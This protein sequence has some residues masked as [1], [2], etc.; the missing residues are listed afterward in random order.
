MAVCKIL[1]KNHLSYNNR[2]IQYNSLFNNF[3]HILKNLGIK[4]EC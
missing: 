3:K 2:Y 1:L 4:S